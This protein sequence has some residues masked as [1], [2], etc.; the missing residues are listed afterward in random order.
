MLLDLE[1]QV[2]SGKR[3]ILEAFDHDIDADDS[4]GKIK[5]IPFVTLIED[6]EE[7][8]YQ[9][10]LYDDGAKESGEVVFKT[11][12][13]CVPPVPQ[14]NPKLNRNCMLKLKILDLTTFKD[15]DTF[16]KQDPLV[17]FKYNNEY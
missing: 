11:K 12:F 2:H 10:K 14:P 3:F 13:I 9:L 5:K 4:L 6:E 15:A 17:K 7:H 8:E 1:K 16:G